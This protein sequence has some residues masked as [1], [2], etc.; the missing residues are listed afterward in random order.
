M[1]SVFVAVVI[2]IA[3]IA[4]DQLDL[5][6][7]SAKYPEW[8][9]RLI[10]T[11]NE[12]DFS[13][14]SATSE[15]E[16]DEEISLPLELVTK[17]LYRYKN[18]QGSWVISDKA[19]EDTLYESF[20]LGTEEG[21]S[22]EEII[23]QAAVEEA[24][25]PSEAELKREAQCRYYEDEIK[26]YREKMRFGGPSETISHWDNAISYYQRLI[27]SSCASIEPGG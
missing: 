23:A 19:P 16:R 27:V 13:R 20:T 12:G 6:K 8:A 11:I 5:L 22:T 17:T 7:P 2:L 3:I 4:V 14:L 9:N 21:F 10:T 1:K 25:T 26:N 24:A 15:Q 18:K